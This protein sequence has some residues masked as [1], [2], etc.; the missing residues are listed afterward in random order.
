MLPGESLGNSHMLLPVVCRHVGMLWQGMADAHAGVHPRRA[1]P[2][3]KMVPV[4]GSGGRV[5][6]GIHEAIRQIGGQGHHAP[7]VCHKHAVGLCP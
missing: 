4:L 1:T 6:V 2:N 3:V 5:D 7:K